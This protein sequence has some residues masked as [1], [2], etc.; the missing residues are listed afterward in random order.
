[1][2]QHRLKWICAL[3]IAAQLGLLS[4]CQKSGDSAGTRAGESQKE[5]TPS[6][7]NKSKGKKEGLTLT[8]EEAE[9]AGLK[10][11]AL[12]ERQVAEQVILTAT[13]QANQ[14]RL[15]HVAPRVPSRIVKVAANLGDHVKQ[16][17][18]MALLDSVE[19]GEAHSAY[20][21]A[22]TEA[23]LA[24]LNL[25]RAEGLYKEQIVPQKD[26]LRIRAEA[27]IADAA[28]RAAADRVRLLGVSPAAVKGN[29]ALSVFPLISPFS[30]TI[31]EK[32]A[33]LGELAQP[34]KSLFTVADLSV[35]WIEANVFEADLPK[36]RVGAKASVTVTAYPDETFAGRVA[37]ISSG[38]DKETRTVR[39]RI[40]VSNPSSRLKPEMFATAAIETSNARKV[41]AVPDDAVV[42]L[43][44]QP[45]VFVQANDGFEPRP[46]QT[47]DKLRGEVVIKS[48]VKPGEQAVV[49]GAYALKAKLLKSQI[50]DT[51]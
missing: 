19:L 37:Y 44:G 9:V 10:V 30:G 40:E 16:G 17:Q 41:L 50:G 43:Q 7:H 46:V 26:Y 49:R 33:I 48:G 27:E 42:L 51:H 34:D 18:T 13:I 22:R 29:T 47:G 1:M 12:E 36:V 11:T 35:L 15:A 8:S 6:G 32:H 2:K 14:D 31:T 5:S 24:Q 28:E 39:A 3:V 25:E 4:G 20:L 21:K 45:T 38:L 23:Q